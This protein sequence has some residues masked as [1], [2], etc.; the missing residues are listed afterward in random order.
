MT[1]DAQVHSDLDAV[2]ARVRAETTVQQTYCLHRKTDPS[3]VEGGT[4]SK[5]V[6]V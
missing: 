5:H 2:T 6:H 1:T 3:L 4:V